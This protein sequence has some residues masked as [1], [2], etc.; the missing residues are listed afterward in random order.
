MRP[1]AITWLG[2]STFVVRTPGG[3][4]ILFDPWLT[5]NPSCPDAFKRPPAV[6][7]ILVSHG[8]E[9]HIGDLLACARDGRA[10][11]GAVVARTRAVAAPDLLGLKRRQ[12]SL[13]KSAG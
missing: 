4:R 3:V 5:G 6:D 9:D 11:V 13:Y 2:H 1:L 12:T 10:A 7:L 8:H